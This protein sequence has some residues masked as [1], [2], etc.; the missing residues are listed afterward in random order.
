[1]NESV[2]TFFDFNERAETYYS[3]D[4]TFDNVAYRIF[5][6]GKFPR[7]RL[8]LFISERNLLGF[9]IAFKNFEFVRFIKFEY[10]CGSLRVGPT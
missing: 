1:M 9:L 2:D 8:E 5:I 10:V 3:Y 4:R 6:G 7:L